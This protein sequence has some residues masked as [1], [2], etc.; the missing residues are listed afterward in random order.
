MY[1]GNL[2]RFFWLKQ[3]ELLGSGM[4]VIYDK[5]RIEEFKE[6]SWKEDLLDGLN[7]S[8]GFLGESLLSESERKAFLTMRSGFP[9][10]IN[11]KYR[12]LINWEDEMDPIRKLLVPRSEEG[13][14]LGSLDTSGEQESTVAKGLQHKYEQTAVMIVTQ[15]CAAHCRYCFR[16]RLMTKSEFTN[17]SISDLTEAISYIKN[18]V[19]I[20]NVLLSGGDPLISSNMRLR[21]IFVALENIP[22]VRQIRISTKIPAFLPSRITGDSGFRSLLEDFAGRFHF[23]IQCHFDHPVELTADATQCIKTLSELGVTL[24][25]QVPLIRGVNDDPKIIAELYNE[26]MYLGVSPQYLFH[27]RPVKHATHFT[28]PIKEGLE[29]VNEAKSYCAGPA[30][31]FRYVL[32]NETGKLEIVGVTEIEKE[33]YLIGSW[34]QLRRGIDR[35]N[36]VELFKL[37]ENEKWIRG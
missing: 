34:H 26:L 32:A 13:V 19:E 37:K 8:K 35:I 6:E 30:K 4:D 33:E 31:R 7:L 21:K 10:H 20:N 15:A 27:P 11:G 18:N 25:S 9:M 24:T 17:E 14:S 3:T 12:D 2:E 28:I 29:I 5:N 22:H 16:R 1:L 36:P 23:V